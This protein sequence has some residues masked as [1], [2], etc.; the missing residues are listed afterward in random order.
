L[1]KTGSDRQHGQNDAF[2]PT[3]T[4]IAAGTKALWKLQD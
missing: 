1:G 3:E 4:L 2:D